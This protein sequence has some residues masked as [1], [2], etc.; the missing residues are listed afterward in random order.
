MNFLN[1]QVERSSQK[2]ACFHLGAGR[3]FC[4]TRRPPLLLLAQ[5]LRRSGGPKLNSWRDR[6]RR[7]ASE[8]AYNIELSDFHVQAKERQ[9]S[10]QLYISNPSIIAESQA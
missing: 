7:I 2:L 4:W 6:L 1:L 3:T 10:L 9:E 8:P 5:H